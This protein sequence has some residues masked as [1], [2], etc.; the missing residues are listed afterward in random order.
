M[1]CEITVIDDRK[2]NGWLASVFRFGEIYMRDVKSMVQNVIHAAKNREID[3]LNIIDHGDEDGIQIGDDYVSDLSL[4]KFK[5]ALRRL[6]GNFSDDGFVHLQHCQVGED[7]V[8]LLELAKLWGVCV[9]AGTGYE[10]GVFRFNTG[11]YVC[12]YPD[13]TT[14]E[15]DVE[16]P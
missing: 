11:Y 7:R 8:L 2:L 13:G 14:F 15:T 3:R 9:Y 10:Q 5:P 6:R 1:G 16:R 4:S 12:A